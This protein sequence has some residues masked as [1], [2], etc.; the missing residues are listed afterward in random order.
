VAVNLKVKEVECQKL[1]TQIEEL[2]Q[3]LTS[4]R[5]QLTAKYDSLTAILAQSHDDSVFRTKIDLLEVTNV[6]LRGEAAAVK[7]DLIR[8]KDE[9]RALK[10]SSI[11]SQDRIR[12]LE[13]NLSNAQE[14]LK[15]AANEQRKLFET[16]R[17]DML[18]AKQEVGKAADLARKEV[19]MRH[20]SVIKNLEQSRKE[21]VV[22]EK[23]AIERLRNSE[24]ENLALANSIE[25]L[26]FEISGY[27]EKLTDQAAQIEQLYQR[28][29][30]EELNNRVSVYNDQLNHQAAKIEELELLR[31]TQVDFELTRRQEIQSV[32]SDAINIQT[33]L[34]NVRTEF[35]K[36]LDTALHSYSEIESR[37][38]QAHASEMEKE[39]LRAEKSSLK[40][41]YN[42]LILARDALVNDNSRLEEEKK[43][44]N[45]QS[46]QL[47][48]KYDTL[49]DSVSRHLRR[50]GIL[51]ASE[52][53]ENWAFDVP[54]N[55]SQKAPPV[56]P[57]PDEAIQAALD[58]SYTAAGTVIALS[59]H[60]NDHQQGN[61]TTSLTSMKCAPPS[62]RFVE[63]PNFLQS[64]LGSGGNRSLIGGTPRSLKL[65][66][67]RSSNPTQQ[68][69]NSNRLSTRVES[70]SY[71]ESTTT[72]MTQRRRE[73]I[74][75]VDTPVNQMIPA[76]QRR[77]TASTRSKSPA[78]QLVTFSQQRSG[79]ITS[80]DNS[81][82]QTIPFSQIPQIEHTSTSSPLSD[83]DA[84]AI[85]EGQAIY[86]QNKSTKS[87]LSRNNS[88]DT[89]QRT[90]PV[91]QGTRKISC[92]KRA[93]PKYTISETLDDIDESE[94][95]NITKQSR[96]TVKS[97]FA[98]Q[99][100]TGSKISESSPKMDSINSKVLPPKPLKSAMKNTN[101]T[102]SIS[103]NLAQNA[104]TIKVSKIPE[105]TSGIQ[106]L[107]H[108]PIARGLNRNLSGSMQRFSGISNVK[109]LVSGTNPASK[110][111][112]NDNSSRKQQTS[113]LEEN[114]H[115]ENRKSPLMSAPQRNIMKRKASN[116]LKDLIALSKSAKAPRQ[117]TNFSAISRTEVPDSQEYLLKYH[118]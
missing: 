102:A 66:N 112:G 64:N 82:C 108:K 19:Q 26:Q 2:K 70:S 83:V 95:V 49:A 11:Q 32:R 96:H 39:I 118:F 74:S 77:H 92:R 79:T 115:S 38:Q 53:V 80:P 99:P 36:K 94:I 37:L 28:P 27:Q 10:E 29:T 78:G 43:S 12:N 84:S 106:V 69:E 81:S 111:P 72:H 42:K 30:T 41:E 25:K 65:A 101:H 9:V 105:T 67:R 61:T 56:Y 98:S 5:S 113:A 100:H 50:Q 6:N 14:S 63:T 47:Q 21:A 104:N 46:L 68:F 54:M 23:E 75:R 48:Q 15:S 76:L 103:V 57:T 89:V 93:P 34:E 4:C 17:A 35:S 62:Q 71:I 24:D 20:E 85:V 87:I 109:G 86:Q 1:A 40:E 18:R 13:G 107:Q 73:T 51:N 60:Q 45:S 44:L 16:S 116:D 110:N 8:F 88:I 97:V 55:A 58:R 33:D 117:S 3:E 31:K 52:S 114:L 22:Q 7:Q 91:P 90:P 59:E